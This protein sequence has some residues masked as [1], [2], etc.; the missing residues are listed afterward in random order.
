M[1][2]YT[3]K[4]AV[5]TGGARRIGRACADWFLREGAYVAVNDINEE[6][7]HAFADLCP[8]RVL[9]APGDVGDRAVLDR[10]ADETLARWGG[11]DFLINNAG[12]GHFGILSD[13]TYDD[14]L[15]IQ[16]VCSAAPFYLALRFRDFFRP[17]AA[18]V[19]I[20]SI[21]AH[22]SQPNT[23]AYS[24]GKGAILS[25][26]RALAMSLAPK[27]R[28]NCISP[29][30]I[31]GW[32]TGLHS[33]PDERQQPVGFIGNADDIAAAVCFL[34]SR[35]ARFITGQNL[36]I[37]GGM[38]AQLIYHGEFGWTFTPPTHPNA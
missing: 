8:D 32:N 7:G 26:T 17:D 1:N 28:V 36:N 22:A 2:R 25:L 29:G 31:K 13:C 24:A 34:C 3:D 10:L 37:D 19:N 5:I 9:F 15:Y 23:E 6:A 33:E 12:I 16:R 38:S 27:V 11:V 35:D 30:W 14:F 4:V 21:R 20:S 18:I